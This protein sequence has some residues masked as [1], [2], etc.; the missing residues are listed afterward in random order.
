MGVPTTVKGYSLLTVKSVDGERRVIEGI[1]TSAEP[2]R[3]NDIVEP[4]GVTFKNPLPLLLYHDATK[5]VGWVRLKKPTKDG[6][7]FEAR[8]PVIDDPPALRDRVEEAWQ[9]IKTRL[10]T[11]VSIGFRVLNDA[12]DYMQDTGGYRFRE[13]EILEL[14]LVSIP[15]NSAARISTV[16]SLDTDRPAA[17]GI[18]A[19]VPRTRPVASGFRKDSTMQQNISDLLTTE[20]EELQKKSARFDELEEKDA[21]EGGLD[22][23]EAKE[24]ET[25][26]AE[27]EANVAKIKRLTARE[28]AS[29][30]QAQPVTHPAHVEKTSPRPRIEVVDHAKELPKGTLFARYAMAVA[31]GRGSYSDT[32]AYAKRWDAQTPEVSRYIKAVEGTSVVASPGWGGELVFQNNLASEFV[33]LVRAQTLIGR[34][35]GFRTVPFNVRIPVQSGGST[36]NWVGEAAP[37]PVTELAFT[38]MTVP[39]HKIAGIIILTEELVRLSSPDAEATVR[40][41]LT[42]QIAQFMDEQFIQVAIASGANNPASITNGVASP[43]ASGTTLAALYADLATA[44]ATFDTANITTDGLVIVTTPAVA[45]IL[46]M[47]TTTLGQAPAGFNVMPNGGTLLGYPVFVST[48]VDAGTIVI[49]K[50]SEVFLADDGRVSLDASKDATIDMDGGSTPAFSLW[51]KD[52]IGIRA[53]RWV[54]WVKR[55]A[56]AVAVIDTVAYVPGT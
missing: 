18:A 10:V 34:I 28:S 14:S 1:A 43:A 4:L 39:Y 53:E 27:I 35:P 2:D 5:P 42:E 38:T 7:E 40:R 22:D 31:A 26:T 17:P 46:S 32:L 33:E 25:L 6:V 15:A 3:I 49:F 56:G 11:G 54:T 24:R 44:L 48:S 12:V 9:S 50:P 45:R 21:T 16:K 41:D 13:T 30:M 47:M 51:Q 55:R 37:K 29:A 20:R 8:L 36:V 52:C 23:A 19:R